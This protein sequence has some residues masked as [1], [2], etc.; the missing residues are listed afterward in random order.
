MQR[1]IKGS[2]EVQKNTVRTKDVL[3]ELGNLNNIVVRFTY[4]DSKYRLTTLFKMFDCNKS[5]LVN[6]KELSL[7]A[8]LLI[9]MNSYYI[10]Q[11]NYA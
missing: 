10:F 2:L 9:R 11:K 3:Q 5:G 8:S 1:F 4:G 7:M 6:T